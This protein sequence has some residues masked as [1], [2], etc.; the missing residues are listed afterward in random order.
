MNLI[1]VHKNKIFKGL[2]LLFLIAM[3]VFSEAAFRGASSGLLLWFHNVLPTLL[4][5][6]IVSNLIIRLNI[7]K[8]ISKLFY[9]VLGKLFRISSEGC[10]PIVIGFLSGLPMGAKT[11]AD[12]VLDHR[13]S[14]SEGQFLFTMC[15]NASPMFIIG[16]IALTQ[17]KLPEMKYPLFIIIHSSFKE[18]LS[19]MK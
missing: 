19:N 14:R 13:I 6:I 2:V 8:Q 17:L 5:F 4:P 16:Y 1:K 12:L 10:Y 7:S 18:S 9:P 3:L 11:S 15:N